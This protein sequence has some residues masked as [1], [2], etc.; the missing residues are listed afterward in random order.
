MPGIDH[1]QPCQNQGKQGTVHCFP[2]EDCWPLQSEIVRFGDT[3]DGELLMPD[4]E[5]YANLTIMKNIRVTKYPAMIAV[6][7]T[8]EDVQKCVQW[9]HAKSIRLVVQSSGHDFQGRSTADGSLMVYLGNMTD[10]SINLNSQRSDCPFGEISLESGNQW[11]SV[12]L[13]VNI[14]YLLMESKTIVSLHKVK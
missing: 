9:A 14:F 1:L 4:D 10:I 2:G 3:L 13:E 8:V 6:I 12:Y 7:K 5:L 11:K